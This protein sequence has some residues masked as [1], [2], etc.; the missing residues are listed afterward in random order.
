MFLKTR[1]VQKGLTA[2]IASVEVQFKDVLFLGCE[3]YVVFRIEEKYFL[4]WNDEK[5]AIGIGIIFCFE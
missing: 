3:E 5:D 4:F 1:Y 2:S